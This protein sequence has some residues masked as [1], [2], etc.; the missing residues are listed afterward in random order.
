MP[1]AWKNPA[2][3][4]KESRR[5]RLRENSMR[6]RSKHNIS[7]RRRLHVGRA[8]AGSS[9]FFEAGAGAPPSAKRSSKVYMFG[10]LTSCCWGGHIIRS[11]SR[12]GR[13][14]RAQ[15]LHLCVVF[16]FVVFG[17]CVSSDLTRLARHVEVPLNC[18]CRA[19]GTCK[20]IVDNAV[21]WV[22]LFG[23]P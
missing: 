5:A 20:G 16:A 6:F 19:R 1:G 13:H 18:G 22:L 15:T 21:L 3:S 9:R 17:T 2:C 23:V 14:I 11:R 4:L 7:Y 12:S 8:R 10:A